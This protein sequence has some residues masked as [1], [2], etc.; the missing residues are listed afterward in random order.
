MKPASLFSEFSE[1]AFLL[2]QQIVGLAK[3][4]PKIQTLY[5]SSPLL[6]IL[7]RIRIFGVGFLMLKGFF[8]S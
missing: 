4:Y 2:H 3:K 5:K 1:G 6:F 8:Y 7:E